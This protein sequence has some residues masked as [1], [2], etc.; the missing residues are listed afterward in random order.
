MTDETRIDLR[1]VLPDIPD[2]RDACVA[3]LE[4]RLGREPGV[5]R[6]HVVREN[7]GPA[8]LCLHSDPVVRSLADVERLTRAAG[9]EIHAR[10]GHVLLAIRAVSSEDAAAGLEA[11]LRAVLG[12][13]EAAVSLPAQQVRV[14]F[15]RTKTSPARL[16]TV[17]LELGFPAGP[18][19]AKGHGR[20][21]GGA[22]Q[23]GR[24][25]G[26]ARRRSGHGVRPDRDADDRDAASHGPHDH[27]RGD[28]AGVAPRRG[29]RRTPVP[30]PVGG[31]RRPPRRG[32]RVGPPRGGLCSLAPSA[33][34]EP[35]DR[36]G[37]VPLLTP[38]P[39]FGE[40]FPP[41]VHSEPE[42][43]WRVG[44]RGTRT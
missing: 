13:I 44:T 24:T 30:A 28:R 40:P 2:E 20:A 1:L 18:P 29:G 34:S 32:R 25:P 26:S 42:R 11:A 4:S 12:V 22:D 19:E 5:I 39:G 14:E 8:V 37:R 9:A 7:G 33:D 38:S 15:E 21:Q 35:M 27:A 10:Y 23:R 6:A 3:R 16:H 31:R 36:P 17:L 43:G 41:A